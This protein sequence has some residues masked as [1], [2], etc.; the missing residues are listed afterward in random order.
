MVMNLALCIFKSEMNALIIIS[1]VWDSEGH[2]EYFGKALY[3]AF[4]MYRDQYDLI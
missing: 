3:R 1:N 4:K 2:E